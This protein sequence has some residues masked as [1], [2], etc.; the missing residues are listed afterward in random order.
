MGKW[1][2]HARIRHHTGKGGGAGARRLRHYGAP[3]QGAERAPGRSTH[4]VGD[5]ALEADLLQVRVS[6]RGRDR[7]ENLACQSLG[8]RTNLPVSQVPTCTGVVRLVS[9]QAVRRNRDECSRRWTGS[10]ARR[11]ARGTHRA[12]T[13]AATPVSSRNSNALGRTLVPEV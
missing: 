5:A 8:R 7:L 6:I 10:A 3:P 1:G 2:C 12:A 9:V 13:S 11:R 4:L